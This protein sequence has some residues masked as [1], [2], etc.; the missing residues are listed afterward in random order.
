MKTTICN[1]IQSEYSILDLSQKYFSLAVF[2]LLGTQYVSAQ[3]VDS[4]LEKKER[5]PQARVTGL[6][7][8]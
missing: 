4:L 1:R 5:H 8:V 6:R 7:Y 2:L 3:Q